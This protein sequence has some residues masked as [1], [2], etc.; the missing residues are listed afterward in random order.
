MTVWGKLQKLIKE[1]HED[2]CLCED[3]ECNV[4]S[5]LEEFIKDN[6]IEK[7]IQK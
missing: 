7:R 6:F 3:C 2:V 1:I 4:P 5:K